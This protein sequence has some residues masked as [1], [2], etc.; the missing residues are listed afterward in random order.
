[1]L[2]GSIYKCLSFTS[3]VLGQ[4]SQYNSCW[5]RGSLCRQGISSVVLV[6]YD[7]KRMMKYILIFSN[8]WKMKPKDT[9]H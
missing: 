7:N 6:M 4:Q 9:V 2:T 8:T 5:R 3:L 1:M